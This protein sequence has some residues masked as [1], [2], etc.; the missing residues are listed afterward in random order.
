MEDSTGRKIYLFGVF[1]ATIVIIVVLSALFIKGSLPDK[2]TKSFKQK[3]DS[4]EEYQGAFI[5]PSKIKDKET[6]LKGKIISSLGEFVE[7]KYKLIDENGNVLAFLT[8]R[9]DLLTFSDGQNVQITGQV[10][11]VTNE[12][13]KV[14]N[15]ESVQFK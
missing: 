12:G 11:E 14:I 8:A 15:V 4:L 3:N 10:R 5:N 6:V 2:D 7:Y 13:I 1:S 9:G